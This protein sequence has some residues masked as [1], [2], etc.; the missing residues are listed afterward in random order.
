[1]CMACARH[2]RAQVHVEP[3]GQSLLVGALALSHHAFFRGMAAM[4]ANASREHADM[5]AEAEAA[6]AGTPPP[7]DRGQAAR[8]PETRG[9]PHLQLRPTPFEPPR[10]LMPSGVLRVNLTSGALTTVA[11][12]ASL[13]ASSSWGIQTHRKLLMGSPWDDGVVVC[14]EHGLQPERAL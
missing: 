4:Q 2:V 5:L 3:G 6:E 8:H 9:R 12:Q 7:A 13:L 10:P 11:L 14:Y 1:M